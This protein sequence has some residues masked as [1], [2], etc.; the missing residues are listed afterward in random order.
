MATVLMTI[1]WIFS[2]WDKQSYTFTECDS[3]YKRLGMINFALVC[4]YDKIIR[5]KILFL[6]LITYS[7]NLYQVVLGVKQRTS[8]KCFDQNDISKW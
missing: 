8:I 3:H 2:R 4:L 7:M 1:W 6:H 5:E